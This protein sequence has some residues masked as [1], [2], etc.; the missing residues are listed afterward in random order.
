MPPVLF[1]NSHSGNWKFRGRKFGTDYK[2]RAAGDSLPES[3][4]S[5]RGEGGTIQKPNFNLRGNFPLLEIPE[6]RNCGALLA[7]GNGIPNSQLVSLAGAA[8]KPEL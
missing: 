6:L 4:G 1:G 3:G 7:P 2:I 5:I 8:A